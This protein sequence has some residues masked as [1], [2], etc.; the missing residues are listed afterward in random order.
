MERSIVHALE[1]F[2][3]LLL[4]RH[5]VAKRWKK[6]GKPVVGWTCTY[7]PEEIIYAANAL[8][9]RVLGD[10]ER[11]PLADAYLPQ[12]VCS[13]CRSCFDQALR[14][15]YDYLDGYTVSNTCDSCGMMYGMWKY[16][17]K[18][19]YFYFINTPHTKN[20]KAHNFFYEEV[21]KLKESLE[22]NFKTDISKESLK[23]AVKVYN[24]NRVL[25]RKVY[26]LRKNSP[27]LI[28]GV[29]A[30][31]I[32]LSSMLTSKEEH[33]KLLKQLL[34]QIENRIDTSKKGIRL[35]VSGSVMDNTEMIK[36]VEGTG[37]NVVADDLC[38]GSRYFWNLVN[39]TA[40]P[41]HAIA[42]R[43]LDKIP[44]PFTAHSMD[45]FKHTLEMAK[46]YDVEGAII[47]VLKFCDTH[48]FDTPILLEKLKAQGLPVL[49]LEWEHAMSGI[50]QLKTRIEAF[51]EMISGVA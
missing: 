13:F 21:K 26:D 8:P 34:D 41:L 7:T 22:N 18:V 15:K 47:F 10:L 35:L 33:N 49:Y 27:P 6:K 9:V 16:H 4:T 25:L 31:E 17:V 43:Y 46:K 45:R 11:T 24:E 5:D 39:P 20:E 42:N 44:C 12:N 36:I 2:R 14:G 38:T 51:I 1:S 23:N 30:L 48:L 28:S 37:A 19:P 3:N 40:D 50:A 29:E 32:V